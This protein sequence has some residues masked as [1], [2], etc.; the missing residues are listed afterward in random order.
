MAVGEDT[1][2]G[3]G[4]TVGIETGGAGASTVRIGVAVGRGSVRG[5]CARGEATIF[6][7]GVD[8]GLAIGG[9]TGTGAGAGV[10]GR[11]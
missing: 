11:L 6:G 4:A 2:T 9:G 3:A 10:P 8:D 7:V 1:V 5:V